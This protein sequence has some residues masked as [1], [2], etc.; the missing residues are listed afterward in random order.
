MIS[1]D[2]VLSLITHVSWLLNLAWI[3]TCL[4]ICICSCVV[5]WRVSRRGYDRSMEWEIMIESKSVTQ[6]SNCCLL[7]RRSATDR[8]SS[9]SCES[10]IKHHHHGRREW[11]YG[12]NDYPAGRRRLWRW[13]WRRQTGHI[14]SS[15]FHFQSQLNP[16]T[17]HRALPGIDNLPEGVQALHELP[18]VRYHLM[19]LP[20]LCFFRFL[21]SSSIKLT[22]VTHFFCT[23]PPGSPS[24]LTQL[25]EQSNNPTTVSLHYLNSS[26]QYRGLIC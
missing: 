23:L 5:A 20:R 6:T 11:P 14:R 17:L 1:Y 13:W 4:G 3:K 12:T 19:I 26:E 10:V 2:V 16:Q 15:L 24:L 8:P 25:P 7:C 22:L 21:F 9:P 18:Q